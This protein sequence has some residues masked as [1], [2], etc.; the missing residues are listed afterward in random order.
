MFAAGECV[1]DIFLRATKDV[2]PIVLVIMKISK[3][4]FTHL[5]RDLQ[6]LCWFLQWGLFYTASCHFPLL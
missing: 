1:N 2:L 3:T 4:N 5:S 6:H